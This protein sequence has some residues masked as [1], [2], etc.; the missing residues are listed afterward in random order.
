VVALLTV[1][2]VLMRDLVV[3]AVASVGTVLVLPTVVTRYFPGTVSAALALLAAGLLLVAAAVLAAW[4]PRAAGRDH[5][6]GTSRDWTTGPAR[7][8]V[9]GAVALVAGATA[10]VLIAGQ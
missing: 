6:S 10:A 4:R 1:A 5:P 9:G 8:A 3:L 7:V 2:A